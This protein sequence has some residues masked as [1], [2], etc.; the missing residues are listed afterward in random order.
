MTYDINLSRGQRK[1]GKWVEGAYFK[2]KKEMVCFANE[3]PPEVHYIVMDG[4]CD[5]GFE[6]PIR[7]IEVVGATVGRCTGIRDINK[8]YIFCGDVIK[9]LCNGLIGIVTFDEATA[10]F[11][12]KNDNGYFG[13]G[14]EIE[15]APSSWEVIGN[16]YDNP[17]LL[18]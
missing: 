2:H 11:K 1:D 5:W 15:N 10:S 6:P 8:K 16:V 14:Y 12:L 17:E 13:E 4:F 3:S 18:E 9:E 7:C